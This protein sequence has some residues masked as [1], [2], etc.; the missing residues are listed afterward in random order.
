[1]PAEV[2][3][4][5]RV[6][7]AIRWSWRT[8]WPDSRR[9][10]AASDWHDTRRRRRPERSLRPDEA[11]RLPGDRHQ[12]LRGAPRRDGFPGR[13]RGGRRPLQRQPEIDAFSCSCRCPPGST[14]SR[15]C[16][17][18]ITPRTSTACTHQPGTARDER[19][20]T[21]SLHAVGHR[22][23]AEGYRVP[24]EGKHVVIIGRGLTIGRPLS[25]LLAMRRPGCNAAVTVVH[26][27]VEDMASLTRT[28]T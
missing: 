18:S 8:A 27:G 25:L 10:A 21:A 24:V 6:A 17:A 9:M 7:S 12:V 16:C 19:A 2:L 15:C 14:R 20:R 3:D 4:G 26:T 1:M 13:R 23:A 22:R 28:R 5:E 11:R